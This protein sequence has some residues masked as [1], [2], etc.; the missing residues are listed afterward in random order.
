MLPPIPTSKAQ[1]LRSFLP[2]PGFPIHEHTLSAL[3]RPLTDFGAV[4]VAIIPVLAV[5]PRGTLEVS[6]QDGPSCAG[7]ALGAASVDPGLVC[8]QKARE[9]KEVSTEGLVKGRELHGLSEGLIF[10]LPINSFYIT[11]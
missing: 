5:S 8:L 11:E 9:R 6:A 4:S 2:Y 7:A 3:S 1:G 10:A